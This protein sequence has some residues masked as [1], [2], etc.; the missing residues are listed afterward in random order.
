[1][2]TYRG[3]IEAGKIVWE[4]GVRPPDGTRVVVTPDAPIEPM[5]KLPAGEVDPFFLIGNEAIETGI[6]DMSVEHDHYAYGTP[7]RN[8]KKDA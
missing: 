2:T 5:A 4:G 3:K 7:K 1:M 6:T 8:Q